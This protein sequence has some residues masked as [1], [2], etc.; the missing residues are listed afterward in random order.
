M[1]TPIPANDMWIAAIVIQ[2]DLVLFGW[3]A[4]FDHL[5]Q[6]ARI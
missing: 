5:R 3:D 4:H 1:G 6:I 2:H